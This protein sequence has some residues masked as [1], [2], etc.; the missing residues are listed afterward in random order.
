MALY[1]VLGAGGPVG[2]FC[3]DQLLSAGKQVR[4]I[5]RNPSKYEGVFEASEGLEVVQGDVTQKE[6][7]EA[8]L[9]GTKGIVFAAAGS[10]YFG[11]RAVENEVIPAYFLY[12]P[13]FS[14]KDYFRIIFT[15][16]DPQYSSLV[17]TQ[18]AYVVKESQF[19]FPLS[20]W[21]V[22]LLIKPHS[23]QGVRNVADVAAKQ[24]AHM[25]LVSAALVTPA[26]LVA[27]CSHPSEPCNPVQHDE[28]EGTTHLEL[29]TAH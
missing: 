26:K 28:R 9:M 2:K 27:P 18:R 11:A 12:Q 1:A 10:S 22:V 5:V 17:H 21:T 3:V 13:V 8:A 20:L 14:L 24:G 7:L 25:V 15:T 19:Y 4:A 29:S 16:K 6:S 23:F